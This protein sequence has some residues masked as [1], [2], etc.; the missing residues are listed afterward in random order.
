MN[1]ISWAEAERYC[2][3]KY[4]VEMRSLISQN[5][6]TRSGTL[7]NTPQESGRKTVLAREIMGLHRDMSEALIVVTDTESWPLSG[8]KDLFTMCLAGLQVE[9]SVDSAPAYRCGKNDRIALEALMCLCL[10]F[11]WEFLLLFSQPLCS[12]YVGDD[13]FTY[14]HEN[15]E[16]QMTNAG[17]LATHF[18]RI[19]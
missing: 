12:V 11:D 19:G 16:Q 18:E 5:D 10:Y 6:A 1:A 15:T 14:C 7:F 2:R 17:V 13:V 3:E 9:A 4:H 8:N